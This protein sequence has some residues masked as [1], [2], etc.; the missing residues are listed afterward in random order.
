MLDH[1]GWWI[2]V[3]LTV[4][5]LCRLAY[6]FIRNPKCPSC[7]E[8]VDPEIIETWVGMN[9]YNVQNRCPSCGHIWF[10]SGPY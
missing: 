8:Y 1:P 6:I 7:R 3:V 2:I 5:F 9:T 4:L 10:E